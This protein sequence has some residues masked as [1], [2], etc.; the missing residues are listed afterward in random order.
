MRIILLVSL[1]FGT[2]M[3]FA[4][5]HRSGGEM[6]RD[7][8]PKD[9]VIK[10]RVVDE[11]TGVAVKFANAA[12]FSLR[13][14]SVVDG[15]VADENGNFELSGL[16]Y[17]RYYL[18]V[19]FIGYYQ[20][21]ISDLRVNPKN[22]IIDLR[23]LFL[24]QSSNNI[25][26]VEITGERDFVEY[27]IDRK[28]INISKNI[29]AAGGSIVDALEKAPSLQV[30]I[31]GNV[32]MRGSS[33][34]TVLIDGKPS[35]LDANDILQQIPASSVENVEIITNPSV[36][37]DPDGTTGIINIIMKKEHK[38]GFNGIVNASVGTGDKF[39]SDFLI[40]YRKKKV[41]YYFGINYGDKK[42]SMD[43]SSLRKTSL[44]DTSHFL[45]SITGRSH[46]RN[47]Y[48]I[49]GGVDLFLNEKNTVSVSGKYGYFGFAMINNSQNTE[50]SFPDN[51]N[52]FSQN[53]G[54]FSVGG[55]LYSGNLD[56]KHNFNKKG[57][58]L[59]AS[60]E[61]SGRQGGLDNIVTENT[62]NSDFSEILSFSK[63]KTF[64]NRS[65]D[66]I[67]LKL[68]YSL[69]IN[70]K[71]KFESGLQARLRN[72]PGDYVLENYI[73]NTWVKDEALSND[74]LYKRN[75][76]S[77]YSSVSGEVFTLQYMLGLRGEYTDRIVE[78]ITSK[79]SY[80]LQIFD[81]F[82]SIHLTK[83]LSET[84]QIQAS[85]SKRINRPRNWYMNPFPGYADAYSVRVGNPALLPEYI[86]SYELSYNKRMK[87]SYFN[88]EAYYRQTN[89]KINRIQELMDDGRILN[90]FDNIDKEFAFGTEISGNFQ[91][92]KWWKVY[93]NVNFYKY[94]LE[95][96]IAGLES[97]NQSI[98]YDF[99]ANTTFMFSKNSRLQ[100]DG[101]YNAPTITSQ[102]NR[103]G[104]YFIS[105]A[106]KQSFFK[107]KLSVVL[108][109]RD[110]LQTGNY[111][112]DVE[113]EGF[114]S[115][116]EMKR[117]S[118]VVTLSLSYKINNYKKKR[119]PRDNMDDE[120]EGGM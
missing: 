47:Y 20:K 10:G 75:I 90:T 81:Y 84:Q 55:N 40:N 92:L 110:I 51:I 118:P 104:F 102:G 80:P 73:S 26:E 59:T 52:T 33:N 119:G 114:S 112:Y 88:V 14:S 74:F 63:Y 48:S 68:D 36:K 72:T 41:N 32:S 65:K 31:D 107:R 105:A 5:G 3:F 100:V 42:F 34:F 83:K 45:K 15:V 13:D 82:P 22:K 24:K 98:N 93:A 103:D 1:L 23:K 79:E 19:D 116:G 60:A 49:K 57:H 67:R 30:D 9:G 54:M 97:G 6:N 44:Q 96:E 120:G 108:R 58:N 8:M 61:Y 109:A 16:R 99:R 78:Q 18:T 11:Q 62:T 101:M 64:Q 2:S 56:F 25:D 117:E 94:N 69:P 50:Y 87:A 115:H 91:I 28:V 29:N 106:Y 71:I 85:Y 4:Q 7:D 35:V 89:N 38:S 70:K 43:G 17:G 12:L 86:D 53:D 76:Y 37:Y 21:T 111:V 66:V 39:S 46:K 27:K 77:A 95:G 113:G